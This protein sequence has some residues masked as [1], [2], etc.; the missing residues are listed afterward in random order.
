MFTILSFLAQII[1]E[2][3]NCVLPFNRKFLNTLFYIS[4]D[5]ISQSEKR[6]EICR[7]LSVILEYLSLRSEV[8]IECNLFSR[9]RQTLLSSFKTASDPKSLQR[10]IRALSRTHKVQPLI[11]SDITSS[12]VI[13]AI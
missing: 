7:I 9:F 1:Y 3:K 8:I 5:L 11:L 2:N 12:G 10:L 4:S 6:K 13:N